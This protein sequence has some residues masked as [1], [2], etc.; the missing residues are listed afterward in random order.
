MSAVQPDGYLAVPDAGDGSGVLVL[1]AWWGLN[2]TFRGICDRLA[3][4]G[5]VAFAPDLFHGTVVDE[6]DEAEELVKALD[7]DQA[8]ADVVDATRF[9]G[10]RVPADSGIAV[11]G[12]SLGANFALDLSVAEPERIRSVALFYGT[13]YADFSRSSAAYLG[14]FAEHDDFEPPAGVD[15][16]EAALRDAGRPVDFYRYPGTGHWFFEPDRLHAYDEAAASL[17]WERTLTFL[18]SRASETEAAA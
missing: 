16:L 7:G 14:H 9:L 13:G 11:I 18:R 8:M 1:H 15:E 5:Y 6:V 17:A 2:D 12:F 10:E 4:E 3:R